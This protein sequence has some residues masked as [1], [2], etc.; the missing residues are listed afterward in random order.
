MKNI[1]LVENVQRKFTKRIT[2]LYYLSY[3]ER[4]RI[5]DLESLELRRIKKDLVF[6]FKIIKNLVDLNFHDFFTFA[7]QVGTRGNSL[8][9]YPKFARKNAVYNS[10]CYRVINAWNYLPDSMSSFSLVIFKKRL[11]SFSND[12]KTFLKGRA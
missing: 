2:G 12:L 1:V 8:K 7:P 5:C 10:F 3:A 6:V 9:L 11:D 4:L